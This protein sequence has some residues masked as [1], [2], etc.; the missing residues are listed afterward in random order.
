MNGR[1]DVAQEAR[2]DILR[3]MRYL[4][5]ENANMPERFLKAFEKTCKTLLD[6][7][8][9]GREKNYGHVSLRGVREFPIVRFQKYLVYYRENKGKL[10][11]VRVLHGAR[12]LPAIFAEE[13]EDD[14]MA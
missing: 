7:P 9:M 14:V 8:R 5:N 10:E 11:V 3:C 1:I 2:R 12:D 13:R 6:M 4:A